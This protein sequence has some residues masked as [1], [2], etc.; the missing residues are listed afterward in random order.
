MLSKEE[1]YN[2]IEQLEKDKIGYLEID[3]KAGAR[4]KAKQ[5][6]VLEMQ[7]KLYKTGKIEKELRTYKE[8]VRDYPALQNE[9]QRRLDDIK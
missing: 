7:L 5:I 8:V 2:K 9:I 4:R 6:E 3:D 1:I